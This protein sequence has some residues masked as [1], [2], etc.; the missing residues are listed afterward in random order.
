M[1]ND[2][3]PDVIVP[4]PAVMKLAERLAQSGKLRPINDL[5]DRLDRAMGRLWGTPEAK[6]FN[7]A[8]GGGWMMGVSDFFDQMDFVVVVRSGAD[9][10]RAVVAVLESDEAEDG[11]KKGSLP[12]LEEEFTPEELAALTGPAG[13]VAPMT[14]ARTTA[15]PA[16]VP[17]STAKPIADPASPTLVSWP[18]PGGTGTSR[19]YRRTTA[20]EV[21]ALVANLMLSQQVPPEDIEVWTSLRQPQV[22]ISIE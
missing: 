5:R 12:V 17:V 14:T 8:R 7:D 16:P 20:S 9:G 19:N 21:Q 3:V 6:R 2:R 22:R 10:V 1:S 18:E 4:L 15:T 13:K 11:V